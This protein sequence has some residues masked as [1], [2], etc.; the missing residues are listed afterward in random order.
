M[1]KLNHPYGQISYIYMVKYN[2][3]SGKTHYVSDTT[4]M[5]ISI[6]ENVFLPTPQYTSNGSCS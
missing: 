4:G 2:H 1:V 6:Y 3:M 5:L